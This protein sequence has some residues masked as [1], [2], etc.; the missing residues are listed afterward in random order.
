[1]AE[2]KAP[3]DIA[4]EEKAAAEKAAKEAAASKAS[5][6]DENAVPVVQEQH[7]NFSLFG[8]RILYEN[9]ANE[10]M[11]LAKALAAKHPELEIA[12]DAKTNQVIARKKNADGKPAEDV[13]HVLNPES[14][15]SWARPLETVANAVS[16]PIETAKDLAGGAYNIGAGIASSI[17]GAGA[18]LT[19]GALTG[20]AA[21]I[22]AGMAAS[23]IVSAGGEGIRQILAN[24]AGVP[25]EFDPARMG[26]AGGASALGTLFF[27][28]GAT[29][30]NVI[31]EALKRGFAPAQIEEMIASQRGLASK[32]YDWVKGTALPKTGAL[33]SGEA[34]E[35]IKNYATKA[36]D[37]RKLE[38]EG[39]INAVSDIH[40]KIRGAVG[41]W[42]KNVGERL[43]NAIENAGQQVEVAEAKAPL[44]KVIDNLEKLYAET[45]TPALKEKLDSVKSTFD[46][47]F[48][49]VPQ[50]VEET[51][52]EQGVTDPIMGTVKMAGK[53]TDKQYIPN[54]VSAPAA[55][56]MKEDLSQLADLHKMQTGSIT[57]R[58]TGNMTKTDKEVAEAARESVK[59][60]Q[61][62][63]GKATENVTPKLNA[64]YK[65]YIDTRKSLA[66]YFNT[67]DKTYQTLRNLKGKNKQ[68]LQEKLKKIDKELGTNVLEDAKLFDAYSTFGNAPIDAVSSGGTTSTSRTVPLS[69]LLGG[70]G[71]SVGYHVA[72]P[73]GGALGF[74]L[75]AMAGAK[76]GSPAAIRA[77]TDALM[78]IDRVVG[79]ARNLNLGGLNVPARLGQAAVQSAAPGVWDA[80]SNREGIG[81]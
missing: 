57:S 33:V 23:G 32:A 59:I 17:A 1:M 62:A 61:D 8:D 52:A 75:G 30:G 51:A 79:F 20:G 49:L 24:A 67:P 16:H 22:P 27:G 40:E 76:A 37:V 78:P 53:P 70:I 7:P 10:P 71:S 56:R 3:W 4:A 50:K 43:S 81:Q 72:G 28:T 60:L 44:Q 41:G 77:Y 80:V 15:Y 64:E 69:L 31:K 73:T 34:S 6:A 54:Q 5:P 58:L 46:D 74:G 66:P 21:A 35:S 45:P 68:I 65:D 63:I 13:F 36:A 38:K 2:E 14:G 29:T 18:G 47:Y 25:Q 19:A 11:A 48:S 12:L 26:V 9:L 42:G 39:V 55:F